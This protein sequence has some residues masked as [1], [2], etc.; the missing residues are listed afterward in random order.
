MKWCGCLFKQKK[1]TIKNSLR[2]SICKFVSR[3]SDNSIIVLV[4]VVITAMI[5]CIKLNI[6]KSTQ[7]LSNSDKEGY[8]ISNFFIL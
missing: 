3:Y 6:T 4:F 1:A 7:I 2:Y 8:T 5:D